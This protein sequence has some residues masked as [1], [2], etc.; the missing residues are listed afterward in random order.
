MPFFFVQVIHYLAMFVI[1]VRNQYGGNY[2]GY[3]PGYSGKQTLQIHSHEALRLLAPGSTKA[4][5][6]MA[7]DLTL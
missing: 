1:S 6:P 3:I 4:F 2:V 5:S 7:F